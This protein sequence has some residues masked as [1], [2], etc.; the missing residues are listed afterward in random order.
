MPIT[1][2][3]PRDHVR[4]NITYLATKFKQDE[5]FSAFWSSTGAKDWREVPQQFDRIKEHCDQLLGRK[6]TKDKIEA[7]EIMISLDPNDPATKRMNDEDILQLGRLWADEVLKGDH[8]Y[9]MFVHRDEDHPHLH[10]VFHAYNMETGKKFRDVHRSNITKYAQVTHKLAQEVYGLRRPV[11]APAL[12]R[13]S[14]PALK[15]EKYTHLTSKVN[16]VKDAI[17]RA[18]VQARD[19]PSFLEGLAAEGVRLDTRAGVDMYHMRQAEYGGDEF[20]IRSQKMGQAYASWYIQDALNKQR[21]VGPARRHVRVLEAALTDKDISFE[22]VAR[23]GLRH[24]VLAYQLGDTCYKAYQT[25][26]G[27][28]HFDREVIG[29]SDERGPAEGLLEVVGYSKQEALERMHVPLA[30]CEAIQLARMCNLRDL[31][32]EF[33]WTFSQFD[34]AWDG[35]KGERELT[36]KVG[37]KGE[38]RYRYDDGMTGV[39][40]RGDAID[41]GIRVLGWER[42]DCVDRLAQRAAVTLREVEQALHLDLP[43]EARRAGIKLEKWAHAAPNG[44]QQVN[45]VAEDFYLHPYR[46]SWTFVRQS[47]P[48]RHGDAIDFGHEILGRPRLEVI[49]DYGARGVAKSDRVLHAARGRA[50]ITHPFDWRV[51]LDRKRGLVWRTKD[52]TGN[53]L[54]VFPSS[55]GQCHYRKDTLIQT[56]LRGDLADLER[57]YSD[58]TRPE[59]I[60]DWA[61]EVR[62]ETPPSLDLSQV[63]LRL[64]VLSDRWKLTLDRD[65]LG[66]LVWRGKH[67][68]RQGSLTLRHKDRFGWSMSFRCSPFDHVKGDALD[69]AKLMYGLSH[70]DARHWLYHFAPDLGQ[71]LRI[72][73]AHMP[74]LASCLGWEARLSHQGILLT[75]DDVELE[76]YPST[77]GWW[78]RT[79]ERKPGGRPIASGE[80]L[81]LLRFEVDGSRRAAYRLADVWLPVLEKDQP[82]PPLPVVLHAL[83]FDLRPVHGKAY[84]TYEGTAGGGVL[85]VMRYPEAWMYDLYRSDGTHLSTG[86]TQDFVDQI[87]LL[88]PQG[89]RELAAFGS[90]FWDLNH[91]SSPGNAALSQ[92]SNMLLNVAGSTQNRLGSRGEEEDPDDLKHKRRRSPDFDIGL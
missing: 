59:V 61:K 79:V 27:T 58:A 15:I 91:S 75:R 2:H 92:L 78:W 35:V 49:K 26:D 57:M 41:F 62:F 42:D 17:N 45:W 39:S 68:S 34:G 40:I 65:A 83:R 46:G 1:K 56:Q 11:E 7:H 52:P 64:L 80:N 53:Q 23:Y 87:A 9:Y 5:R 30:E 29:R 50:A 88:T 72:R 4:T 74:T 51:G 44:G 47:D 55:R 13:P 6:R 70:E 25:L 89:R 67:P 28:W 8:A 43:Q 24:E 84:P 36:L 82:L 21:Q 69:Y 19:W 66:Q 90:K 76:A 3:A 20:R 37:R 77:R 48:D 73:H 32:K 60:A 31:A 38:W 18:R 16:L 14:R 10:L 81:D 33:G 86:N 63:D 71:E 85:H 54:T 12:E 22:R